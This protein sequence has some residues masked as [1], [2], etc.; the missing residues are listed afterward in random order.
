VGSDQGHYDGYT[1]M[2]F[3]ALLGLLEA[4]QGKFLLSSFHNASLKEFT[5]R[6]GWHTVELRLSSAMTH[7]QGRTVRDKVEVL[8]A[9]Y[10]IKAPEKDSKA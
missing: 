5:R 3:D 6:N 2:D 1:Q 4:I 10:P 9:S 8:T 7:G